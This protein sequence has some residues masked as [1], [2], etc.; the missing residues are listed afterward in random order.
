MKL[1]DLLL[2]AIDLALTRTGKMIVFGLLALLVISIGTVQS[3]NHA[4]L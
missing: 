4:A 1:F 2:L 3:I